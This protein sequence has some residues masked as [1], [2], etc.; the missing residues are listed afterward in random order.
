MNDI[1]AKLIE[2]MQEDPELKK[3][4]SMYQEE[5]FREYVKEKYAVE[6][7]NLLA[8]PA[9]MKMVF[10]LEWYDIPRSAYSELIEFH[11]YLTYGDYDKLQQINRWHRT[12]NAISALLFSMI[13]NRLLMTRSAAT[14][15]FKTRRIAR[16]PSAMAIGGLV[17]Y[18]FNMAVL[19]PIYLDELH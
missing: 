17:T 3:E 19:R 12:E 6:D 9:I 2:E 13:A 7:P 11:P 5:S 4:V 1:K 15:I 8:T 10:A 14:S 18:L 16:L